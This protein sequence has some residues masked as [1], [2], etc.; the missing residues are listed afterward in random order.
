MRW[1]LKKNVAPVVVVLGTIV[2][3][4][5][6]TSAQCQSMLAPAGEAGDKIGGSIASDGS[7]V[8]LG[9]PNV[10]GGGAAYVFS[11]GPGGWQLVATLQ[12]EHL[13][14]VASFGTSVALDGN[15]AIVGANRQRFEG[16]EV[17][18]AFVFKRSHDMW[19]LTDEL[20]DP[21]PSDGDAFGYSVSLS[22]NYALIGAPGDDVAGA[23]SGKAIIFKRQ[24]Q[25]WSAHSEL[26]AP[27]GASG[28]EFGFSVDLSGNDAIVGAYGH[29][30]KGVSNT[31][32]AF[33][34]E[35]QGNNWNLADKLLAT[36]GQIG[37]VLG[38]SVGISGDRAVVGAI[39]V[40]IDGAID[41]GAAYIFAR[42]GSGWT[43]ETLISASDASFLDLFGHAV[44][45]DGDTA[46]V[47]AIF[48]DGTV[49]NGGSVYVF[50][51]GSSGWAESALLSA[52]DAVSFGRYGESV[53]LGADGTAAA[54]GA[55]GNASE[56]PGVG[57]TV[58]L[59]PE[60]C[61]ADLTGDCIVGGAD[62][63]MV[64]AAMGPCEGC[65]EDLN[66]DGMVGFREILIIY[67]AW[68]PCD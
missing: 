3:M 28:D 31:G 20:R 48:G 38:R 10:A 54:T 19:T 32:A 52:E 2:S 5:A 14:S 56:D 59:A 34:Y 11:I 29:D 25:N 7:A 51:R 24:G 67:R 1:D 44:A 30:E 22:G 61:P 40:E 39:G 16:A 33:V 26:T 15:I 50:Q 57:Y 46:V 8:I 53:A 27:N 12:P 49:E 62:L 45:I 23:S 63:A 13:S 42:D 60:P 68:G 37:D 41:A 18:A 6:E 21:E 4:P 55:T 58:D 17:G 9:A 66:G 36:N 47:S 43:Q 65:P 35:R 64:Q